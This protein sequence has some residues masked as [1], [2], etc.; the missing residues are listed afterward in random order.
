MKKI[1]LLFTLTFLFTLTLTS[2]SGNNSN[3]DSETSLHESEPVS[4]DQSATEKSYVENY[5]ITL[6]L[7]YGKRTGIY[8][9]QI[10]NGLPSGEGTFVSNSADRVKWT[11][12]GQWSNGHC[13]GQGSTI[14]D[15]GQME[16]GE[17]I[18]DILQGDGL[19]LSKD[20]IVYK[21]EFINGQPSPNTL[22]L[23]ETKS[24]IEGKIVND[25][26]TTLE[27]YEETESKL[28]PQS[29]EFTPGAYLVEKDIQSGIYNIIKVDGIGSLTIK[30]ENNR[31][32]EIIR[33]SYNNLKLEPG[34]TF[35]ISSSA[36]Y[37]FT[38]TE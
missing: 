12:R 23:S 15:S 2:C 24:H 11:Y 22:I 38:I 9:G 7:S 31:L 4:L 29:Y 32:K 8:T 33:D 21:G 1:I 13:N 17:Y 35:E 3:I 37:S 6:D 14:W 27:S 36:K 28:A 20:G 16:I 10:K 5:E 25:I 34:Y 18:N 30:D 19:A 26:E